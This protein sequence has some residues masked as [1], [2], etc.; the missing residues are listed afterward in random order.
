MA[1]VAL[2]ITGHRYLIEMDKVMAGVDRA[3]QRILGTFPDSNFRVLS[4]LAEGADRIL[5]KRLH[6]IPNT[7]LWVPLPVPEEEYLKDFETSESKEEFIYLL[8]KAERV[9]NLPVTGK[10]EEGYLAAGKYVLENSDCLLAIW[11]GKP[12]QGAAGTAEIV[13]M[14]RERG[15]PLAWVHAGNRNPGTNIPSSLGTEQGKVTFEH[16]PPPGRKT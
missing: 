12:A 13:T 2:G 15:L 8:G 6:L 5:A 16:L 4:S 14:A 9:I 7:S 1:I 3:V 11:D 10:R